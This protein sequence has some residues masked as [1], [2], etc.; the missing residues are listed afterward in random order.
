MQCP[1]DPFRALSFLFLV[2]LI[3]SFPLCLV[4]RRVN[5]RIPSI[6]R[7]PLTVTQ[8]LIDSCTAATPG[9]PL[10][11]PA[12]GKKKQCLGMYLTHGYLP[13]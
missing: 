5:R 11:A 10:N 4:H 12:D 6:D 2:T 3:P 9:L 1:G 7:Q 8:Q 13:V